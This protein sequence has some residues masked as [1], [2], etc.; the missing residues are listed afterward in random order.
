MNHMDNIKMNL[1]EIGLYVVDWIGLAQD[2]YRWRTLVN[3]GNEP[4]GYI[5]SWE[6]P[7]GCTTCGL[8]SGTRL[9]RVS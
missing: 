3:S 8:S 6:I 4:S 1:L 7:S 5:K 2:R 9:H